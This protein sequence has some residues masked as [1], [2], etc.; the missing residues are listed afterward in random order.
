MLVC[1]RLP[2]VIN[3]RRHLQV[4]VLLLFS[5]GVHLLP[6]LIH[7]PLKVLAELLSVVVCELPLALERRHVVARDVFRA[8]ARSGQIGR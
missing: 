1:G 3:P 7:L 2:R 5:D 6:L 4:E 8:V